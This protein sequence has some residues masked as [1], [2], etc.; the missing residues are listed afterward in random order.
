MTLAQHRDRSARQAS[1]WIATLSDTRTPQSDHGGAAI[2]SFLEAASHR[3]IGASILREDKTSLS[4]EL[5][6]I[7]AK[8]K[9]D[10]L[11]CT[12]GTGIAPR[13]LAYEA[14]QQLYERV[15]P[16]FG[17]LFR[18]LSWQEI[19][20]AALLSRASAGICGSVLIFSL[21]GSLAAIELA[22]QQLILP[23]MQHLL[24]ELDR[25]NAPG[26]HP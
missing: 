8:P 22:M 7:V 6:K 12:G 1:V 5:R 3:V 14:L 21:P 25:R 17:E 2:R 15:L 24:G 9:V 10:V 13:D 18:M 11:I 26:E 23:E 19:G 4:V 20:S 16:G